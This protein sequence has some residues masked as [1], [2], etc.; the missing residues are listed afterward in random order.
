MKHVVWMLAERP[1]MAERVGGTLQT[2]SYLKE[3]QTCQHEGLK[4]S[5]S[6]HL[7]TAWV[8]RDLKSHPAPILCRAQGC[9][10]RAQLPMVPSNLAL[11]T[12]RDGA[13]QL[14]WAAVPGP[15]CPLSKKKKILLKS[16]L[17]LLSSTLKPFSLVLSVP[18]CIK[19]WSPSSL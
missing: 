11:S 4:S 14:L 18:D 3:M 8:W 17:Y 19:S 13:P 10:P 7:R 6:L 12:S 16:N 9:P 2:L 5:F 1:I 15:H